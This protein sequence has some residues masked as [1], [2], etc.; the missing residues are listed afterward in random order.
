MP[1]TQISTEELFNQEPGST[2]SQQLD[3]LPQLAL[4]LLAAYLFDNGF[5][6]ASSWLM[7]RI[8]Q[9]A[10]RRLRRDLITQF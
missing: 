9:D 6:A 5:Q 2:I 10:L 8:S 3:G 1:V 7:A 4:L